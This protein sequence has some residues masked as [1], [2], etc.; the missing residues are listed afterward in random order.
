M[1]LDILGNN[2]ISRREDDTFTITNGGA[3][4]INIGMLASEWAI[5]AFS[6]L[7]PPIPDPVSALD[8]EELVNDKE[9]S[10][11]KIKNIRIICDKAIQL[12]Q[13]F[14]W[15]KQN[16]NGTFFSFTDFVSSLLSPMQYQSRLIDIPY[17][18]LIVGQNELFTYSLLPFQTI[19]ITFE[20]DEFRLEELLDNRNKIDNLG[21]QH[22]VKQLNWNK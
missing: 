10:P 5:G 16:S 22:I 11:K 8:Y 21:R 20:Y 12:N 17:G 6:L 19:T 15:I 1:Q 2:V 14:T 3:I 13:P 4:A 9:V 7:K 18:N